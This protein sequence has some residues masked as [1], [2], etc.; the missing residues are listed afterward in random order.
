MTLRIGTRGSQL[1][2]TQ[3]GHIAD[4]I[5][6][7][8]GIPT[9]LVRVVTRGDTNM[10]SL[11]SLGG[12]GVFASALREALLAGECDLVVH[13]M[14]DLPTGAVPGLTIGA[15][16]ER[17]DASDVLCARDGLRLAD[18]PAGATVG[19]GSPRRTAQLAARR[20]D[21]DIRDIR[22]NVDTRLG[23]VDSGRL[24]A[25]ILAAA[26]LIRLGRA[27]RVTEVFPLAEVPTAPAQGA[28]AL[29]VREA[30]EAAPHSAEL[31][32]ALAAVNDPG[33][34]A[35]AVAERAVLAELGAGCAAPV[36]ASASIAEGAL[37]LRALITSI[38]GSASITR[39]AR[40]ATSEHAERALDQAEALGRSLARE[41]LAAGADGIAP[42]HESCG[43]EVLTPQQLT[44]PRIAEAP[45]GA[46]AGEPSI[47]YAS[48]GSF[49]S[50]GA[51]ELRRRGAIP[52]PSELIR[53]EPLAGPGERARIQAALGALAAGEY[54]WLTVTSPSAVAQLVA[55]GMRVSAD[56]R[57]AAVGPGTER[58]LAEAGYR[59]D[60]VPS[61][62]HSAAGLVRALGAEPVPAKNRVLALG[63]ELAT[64]TL[65]SG[66]RAL[67]ADVNE[68]PLY[69]T[70]EVPPRPEVRDR[71]RSGTISAVLVTSG[72]VARALDGVFDAA[73]PQPEHCLVIA[74]GDP[75]A[76]AARA[77]GLRVDAI[78]AA[79]SLPAMLAAYAEVAETRGKPTPGP[80]QPDTHES[81]RNSQ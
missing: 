13:S 33:T 24:D 54:G 40:V 47:V 75:S 32:Q 26:G 41:L 37:V 16:P 7:R 10:A 8:T 80:T 69:R 25:V 35:A 59:V 52:V 71:L 20:P 64:P 19:T 29:E 56:T 70:R 30:T 48:G 42:L 74:I 79:A 61:T 67:G 36:G 44:A 31:T 1:A 9:E 21:L 57:I 14:K 34:H 76:E 46:V 65:A 5:T 27:D 4:F 58:A 68:V 51:E 12:S 6:T 53:I 81:E 45:R 66:L 11:A 60:V 15:V 3:A 50:G 18:L 77:A 28:L 78:A 39:E 17:V 22:G 55:H 2:L 43:H 62:D 38:D 63:A 73:H 49:G 72:S 23:Y